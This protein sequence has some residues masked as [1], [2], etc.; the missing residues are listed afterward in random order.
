MGWWLSGGMALMMIL[1]GF[2][3]ILLLAG[4]GYFL[5]L[6]TK[7]WQSA[8]TTSTA[9]ADEPLAVLKIRY[10]RGEISREQYQEMLRDLETHGVRHR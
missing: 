9:T 6:L 5:Y 4:V 8:N 7:R 2:F 3:W 1:I 10:A